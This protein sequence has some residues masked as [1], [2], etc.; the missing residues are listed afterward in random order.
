MGFTPLEGLVM[1]TR[2][3]SIDPG[4]VLWLQRHAGV[5]EAAMTEALDQR[6]GLLALAGTADMREV[7]R[8]ISAG[9]DRARLALD[10]Y[11]H[12]LKACI[13]SMAAAMGGLDVLVFTGGVG[14]NA[15]QVRAE[16]VSG[17]RFLGLEI[18]PTLN[19]DVV[20]DAEISTSSAEVPTLVVKAHE[21]IEVA[22]EVRKVLSSIPRP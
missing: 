7:L 2:S 13:A 4:L 15:P 17:L 11:V 12:R 21:D 8:G 16:T 22:R 9:S 5:D 19:A 14:E 1:G 10:V 20:A 3:G 6:S 18:D